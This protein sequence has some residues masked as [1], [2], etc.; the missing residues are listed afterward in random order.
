MRDLVAGS[1]CVS[2]SC[3]CMGS[4]HDGGRGREGKLLIGFEFPVNCTWTCNDEE[5]GFF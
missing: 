2:I 5:R 4:S 1:N 3:W